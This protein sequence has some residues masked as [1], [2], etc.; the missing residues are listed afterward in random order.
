MNWVYLLIFVS[1]PLSEALFLPSNS[2]ILQLP[3]QDTIIETGEPNARKPLQ[4]R[5][6][7]PV[8]FDSYIKNGI[9]VNIT[10]Y[11]DTLSDKQAPNVLRAILALQGSIQGIG[12]PSDT[13]KPITTAADTKG[14][15][16]IDIGFYSLHPPA[17][18][19]VAQASDVLHKMWQLVME[20]Y[21]PKEIPLATILLRDEGIALFRMS[22]REL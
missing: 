10:T 13:L 14:N 9:S 8:P 17:G 19:K 2:S 7:P 11:G 3:S 1:P 4:T 15:L 18:I 5:L 6:W 22:F 16:Y 20:Y 21:P 12:K